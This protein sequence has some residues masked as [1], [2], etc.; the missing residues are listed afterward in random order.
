MKGVA[1]AWIMITVLVF[2]VGFMWVIFSE[3]YSEHLFPTFETHLMSNNDTKETFTY[4][5][6]VWSYW[7]I[8]LIFG[9]IVYGI[10]SALRREPYSQYS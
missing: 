9:L 3:I 10:I 6:N 5:K 1:Y 2:V 4:I 8:I 7:P